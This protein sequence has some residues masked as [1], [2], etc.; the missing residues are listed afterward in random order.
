MY[1]IIITETAEAEY[2][3]A[4]WYYEEKQNG[5]GVSFDCEADQLLKT[6]KKNPLLFQRKY[7]QYREALLRRFPYLIVYEIIHE[8]I[9]V[10]SF[11]HTSRSPGKKY[12][13][14]R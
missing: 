6:I 14:T 2:N 5:L 4:Y 13:R 11:F 3:D 7:K 10:H 8:N 9:I 12:N 1:H